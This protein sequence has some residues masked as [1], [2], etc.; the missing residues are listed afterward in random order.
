[1]IAMRFS[2]VLRELMMRMMT[3]LLIEYHHNMSAVVFYIRV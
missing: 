2:Q 3:L 1:M